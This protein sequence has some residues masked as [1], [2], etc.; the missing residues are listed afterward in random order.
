MGVK[1]RT[2]LVW[3]LVLGAIAGSGSPKKP[4]QTPAFYTVRRDGNDLRVARYAHRPSQGFGAEFDRAAL[5]LRAAGLPDA[6]V[7]EAA[8]SPG[9][10]WLA[11]ILEPRVTGAAGPALHRLVILD[12]S[13]M[14]VALNRQPRR[15]VIEQDARW[16]GADRLYLGEMF[17]EPNEGPHIFGIGAGRDL[18]DVYSLK[19][20][21]WNKPDRKLTG[22]PVE[23]PR[24]FLGESPLA[25]TP[26]IRK[27]ARHLLELGY[28]LP[29]LPAPPGFEPSSYWGH[30]LRGTFGCVSADGRA[31]ATLVG[32]PGVE[33]NAFVVLQE[34]NRWAA[35]RLP[36]AGTPWMVRFWKDWV[37]VGEAEL[38]EVPGPPGVIVPP[39]YEETNKRVKLFNLRDPSQPFEVRADYFLPAN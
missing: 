21:P 29:Y 9:S 7:G 26:V 35:K 32:Q 27:A 20:P 28:G 37:V 24:A 2:L 8:L 23:D 38:H 4:G 19:G 15:P 6:R 1:M 14:R 31:I 12:L 11:L 10:R 13:T 3:S 36:V 25:V 5:D 33:D 17:E 39:R 34:R 16:R 18:F 22:T 30:Y